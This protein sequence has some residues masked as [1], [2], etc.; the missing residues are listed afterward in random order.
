MKSI[1]LTT[2]LIMGALVSRAQSVEQGNSQLYYERYPSAQQTFETVLKQQPDNGQAWY[3]LT[4]AYLL[5]GELNKA[6][7]A[8]GTSSASVKS[9]PWFEAAYGSILLQQNKKDEAASWFNKALDQTKEKDESILAAIAQAHIDAKS[10]DAN[11][12]L[13]LLQKAIKRDKKNAQLETA[14]GDA[15]MKLQ[16][17]TEAYSAYKRAIEKNDKYAAA[18]HKLGEI[19]LSQKNKDLYLEYFNQAIAADAQYAPSIYQLY[20]YE[21][22]HDPAKAMQ[23]YQDYVAKSDASIQNEYDLADLLYLNKDYSKAIEKSKAIIS[24]EK[25]KTQPRLYKLLGYSYA[26]I[27]DTAN[28]IAFM[29][30]YFD[31]ADDSVFIA[32]DYASMAEFLSSNESDSLA[33]VYYAKATEI[34]KDSSALYDDFK[35]LAS[36]AA[37]QKDFSNEAKWRAK[38]YSNNERATNVDLFNWALAHYRAEEYPQADSVFGLYVAKYPD[39]SFGYYW[40]AKS[41]ALQDK[42]MKEGLAVP[43]YEKLA[44]VLEKDTANANYKKWMVEAYGYIAAYEAN[45]KKDYAEAVNYFEKVLEVDPDNADAKKYKAM[46]EKDVADSGTK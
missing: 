26:G 36:L 33:A 37:T 40:Q 20:A 16:N 9:D 13:D 6:V 12:A 31:K 21:F 5:Q 44:E 2:I 18:Y 3:G 42:E 28:A 29:Q 19:F 15:Y 1:I 35:H 45:T 24:A 27:K 38:Y 34:E 4:R 39:Q 32:K 17:G 22:Y 8:A 41:K 14:L 7:D 23:Y 10:G 30:N 25:E 46:F 11:Y 43:A